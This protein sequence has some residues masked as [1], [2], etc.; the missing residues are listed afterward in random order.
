VL[1]I[2][3]TQYHVNSKKHGERTFLRLDEVT[4]HANPFPPNKR[5]TVMMEE[6]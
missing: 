3:K 2:S 5:K 6:T 1:E 4:L